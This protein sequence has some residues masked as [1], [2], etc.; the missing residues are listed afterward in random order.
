MKNEEDV[1]AS[2]T[3][4]SCL[5][6][7]FKSVLSKFEKLDQL[8]EQMTEIKSALSVKHAPTVIESEGGDSVFD[9][10]IQAEDVGTTAAEDDGT[11]AEDVGTAAE[12]DGTAESG[13]IAT[14]H[15][16]H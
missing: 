4:L 3:A 16:D 6:H 1:V 12:E 7:D 8:S 13:L 2:F 14:T 11:S 5:Q 15:T 10:H 9:N